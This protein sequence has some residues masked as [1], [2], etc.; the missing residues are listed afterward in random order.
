MPLEQ[1]L[2]GCEEAGLNREG[3]LDCEAVT[4]EA[5]ADFVRVLTELS[6]NPRHWP[7]FG[8]G[9]YLRRRHRFG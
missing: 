7:G 9:L 8:Y 4:V 3:S 2:S 5:S 6:S 1:H